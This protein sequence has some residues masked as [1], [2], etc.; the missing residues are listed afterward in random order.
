MKKTDI[1]ENVRSLI[2]ED[3]LC[4]FVFSS[5]H[6]SVC[7]S[8]K[9]NIKILANKFSRLKVH[10]ISIDEIPSVSGEFM[11]FTVPTLLIFHNGKE[12]YRASR[13]I[14]FKELEK[15]LTFF[16]QII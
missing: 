12:V 14:S 16:H 11:V 3:A 15:K 2:N 5:E 7:Y 6:C 10:E 8:V 4:L 1:S 13:F 9:E